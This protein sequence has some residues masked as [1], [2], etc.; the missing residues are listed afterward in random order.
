MITSK[1]LFTSNIVFVFDEKNFYAP[2]NSVFASLYGGEKSEGAK[3]LD[4]PIIKTKVLTLPKL[5][6]KIIFD[7]KRLRI[8]EQK[9]EEPQKSILVKE[10]FEIKRKL[11]GE[12][13]LSGFG[14]NFDIYYRFNNVIPINDI[15]SGMFR[16]SVAG[17]GNLL[18]FGF[19]FTLSKNKKEISDTWFIKITAPLEMA[20]HLNRHF[21]AK[22]LPAQEELQK[23]FETC[24]NETD[25]LIQK[26]GF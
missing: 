19:Q 22:K 6:L 21:N 16:D 10:V 8:D 25:E 15:F 13:P 1:S 9:G 14:F 12:H 4:D 17:A 2:D 20:V 7:G 5:G 11:F 18:D 23:L 3:F 24:Y 26:L